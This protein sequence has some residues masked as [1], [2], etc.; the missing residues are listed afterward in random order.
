M[1]ED[2]VSFLSCGLLVDCLNDFLFSVLFFRDSLI[3]TLITL[4]V[5]LIATNMETIWLRCC[6]YPKLVSIV[7]WFLASPIGTVFLVF[8]DQ[9]VCIL[10]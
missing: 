8:H 3:L 2:I 6:Y 9:K 1:V 4:V 10:K 7:G 5:H